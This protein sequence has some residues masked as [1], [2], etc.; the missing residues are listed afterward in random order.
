MW[1][2]QWVTIGY[3]G[4]ASLTK[5]FSLIPTVDLH[6]RVYPIEDLPTDDKALGAVPI[7]VT[8][9]STNVQ[10]FHRRRH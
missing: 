5:W 9:T 10:T 8:V 2:R 6:V 4:K 3:P 1:M 7:S